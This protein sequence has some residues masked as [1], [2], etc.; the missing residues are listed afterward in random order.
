MQARIVQAA[1]CGTRAV[2]LVELTLDGSPAIFVVVLNLPP[3][4]RGKA[5]HWCRT[6]LELGAALEL[7]GNAVS[8]HISTAPAPAAE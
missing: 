7:Y 3:D 4:A 1:Q 2:G 6:E 8:D 5:Q